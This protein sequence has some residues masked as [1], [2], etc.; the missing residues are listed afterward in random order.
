MLYIS[1]QVNKEKKE[2]PEATKS[3]SLALIRS[4][5]Q[6]IKNVSKE[7]P[8][9]TSSASPTSASSISASS[10]LTQN[11]KQDVENV[12]KEIPETTTSASLEVIQNFNED[13]ENVEIGKPET[14]TSASE[15]IEADK[16][17][18]KNVMRGISMTLNSFASKQCDEDKNTNNLDMTIKDLTRALIETLKMKTCIQSSAFVSESDLSND[19]RHKGLCLVPKLIINFKEYIHIII[20]SDRH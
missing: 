16:Q 20:S 5:K 7:N 13:I 15:V 1:L 18:I 3:S 9:V 2:Q 17:N 8:E 11:D 4:D 12:K 6:E 19:C 14:A 10:T